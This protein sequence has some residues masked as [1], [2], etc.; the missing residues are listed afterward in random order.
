MVNFL[1]LEETGFSGYVSLKKRGSRG[2][3]PEKMGPHKKRLHT[4]YQYM[5]T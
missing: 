4:I 5:D 1:S 2:A 3:S